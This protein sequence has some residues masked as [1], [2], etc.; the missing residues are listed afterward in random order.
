MLRP[1]GLTREVHRN[2]KP[3]ELTALHVARQNWHFACSRWI[4][5]KKKI[6]KEEDVVVVL[7]SLFTPEWR[8]AVGAGAG[9]GREMVRPRGCPRSGRTQSSHK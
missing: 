7:P 8:A 3:A 1:N 2:A 6:E 5:R 4:E 9:R